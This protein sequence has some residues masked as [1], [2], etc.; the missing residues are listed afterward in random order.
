MLKFERIKPIKFGLKDQNLSFYLVSI[1][2]SAR[3]FWT[4]H[5]H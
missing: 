1:R 3:T 5:V 2:L 4:T